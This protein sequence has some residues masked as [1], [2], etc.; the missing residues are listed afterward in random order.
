MKR[1]ISL[2]ICSLTLLCIITSCLEDKVLF[3][4]FV[5]SSYSYPYKE[6]NSNNAIE[7]IIKSDR[8]IKAN[9]I[10]AEIPHLKYNKSLLFMFT[11][12]DC[13][14]AAYCRT[15]AAINGRPVSNSDLYPTKPTR[16]DLY[17]DAAQLQ[18]GDLP[19]NVI[20][21]G[22][23]LAYKDGL[24]N[25]IRFAITT[26]LFPEA[27]WME[28]ETEVIKDFT[29][30][31]HRFYM[32]SGLVWDNII[33]MLNYGTGIAFHDVDAPDIDNPTEILQHYRIAQ[34]IIL[35]KLAG[36]GCKMLAEPN[37]NKN[38]LTAALQYPEIQT[39]T[40]QVGAKKLY[41]FKVTNDLKSVLLHRII[42]EPDYFKNMIE[43]Q[44]SLKKEDREAIHV[45]AHG[46]DNKW[47]QF[48]QWI[49]DNYGKDGDD[50][51]WFPSQEEYYEYNYYRIHTSI[52]IEQLDAN[53][54]KIKLNLMGEQYFYYPSIT[55]NLAGIAKE[56]I[57]S[58]SVN[59]AVTGFSYG[60]YANGITMNIDC[61]KNLL[62]N[63]IHYVEL[64]EKEKSNKWYK[65][66]AQYF[67]NMLKESE[68]KTELLNRI[69]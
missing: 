38:Y 6:E 12:D 34:N 46:T 40:A 41:P 2:L 56:N 28:A 65:S 62:Q 5:Y 7:V 55:L 51:I 45:G 24:G 14:H 60:D 8:A 27:K 18:A 36:R 17:Y 66:D 32:K 20:P 35:D 52:N 31:Y 23:T 67:V 3:H 11:Q 19:P 42:E 39:M 13:K 53:S 54:L 29:N 21:A 48:L 10:I 50:S 59:N 49:N 30:N 47:V 15:W 4:P 61:R 44:M 26:T 37:G 64:Y 69:K 68:E 22:N 58:V 25:E 16:K 33:E 57:N 63:A 1:K 43:K 9:D